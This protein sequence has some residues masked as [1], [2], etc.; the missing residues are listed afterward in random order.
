MKLE[1]IQMTKMLDV[2]G[3][4]CDVKQWNYSR[5]DGTMNSLERQANI[6]KFN[7]EENTMI[8]LLSTR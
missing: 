8:F 3:D 2:I 7:T 5:L 4:F 1:I 6:N